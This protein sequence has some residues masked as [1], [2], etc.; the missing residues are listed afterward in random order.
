MQKEKILVSN[1]LWTEK[2]SYRCIYDGAFRQQVSLILWWEEK[3]RK[4]GLVLKT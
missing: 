1:A 3:T 2:S 4:K